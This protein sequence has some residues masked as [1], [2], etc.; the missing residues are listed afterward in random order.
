MYWPKYQHRSVQIRY[1]VTEL[2]SDIYATVFC[3]NITPVFVTSL[4]LR[5]CCFLHA[6][7]NPILYSPTSRIHYYS[8]SIRRA[9]L[10]YGCSGSK[11]VI[12]CQ[13]SIISPMRFPLLLSLPTPISVNPLAAHFGIPVN[14][15]QYLP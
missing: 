6:N 8:S 11:H 3:L 13:Q 10:F 2:P 1:S 7:G 15:L 12:R 9:V 4:T 5:C 14:F